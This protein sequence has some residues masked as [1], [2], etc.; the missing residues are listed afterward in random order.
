VAGS[1][2]EPGP[3]GTGRELD[4]A[5]RNREGT[6]PGRPEPGGDQPDRCP[7]RDLSNHCLGEDS[8]NRNRINA[9]P[10]PALTDCQRKGP[11]QQLATEWTGS[12]VSDFQALAS[13]TTRL[14]RS[15]GA[16]EP[17]NSCP[18]LPLWRR[19]S[20]SKPKAPPQENPLRGAFGRGQCG[21]VTLWGVA[22]GKRSG[23]G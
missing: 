4:R 11:E 18:D 19:P 2:H 7:E 12:E 23:G 15:S 16:E 13:G 10:N 20:S 9:C 6:G 8:Q 21:L 14:P 17:A 1:D 3:A 5:D 22:S